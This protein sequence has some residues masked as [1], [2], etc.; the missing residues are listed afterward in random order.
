MKLKY[1]GICPNIELMVSRGDFLKYKVYWR[2]FCQQKG[3]EPMF[4]VEGT[5]RDYH[6]NKRKWDEKTDFGRYRKELLTLF[7]LHYKN[8]S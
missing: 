1:V 3:I 7:Y 2:D 5:S 6:R 4:T 8:N